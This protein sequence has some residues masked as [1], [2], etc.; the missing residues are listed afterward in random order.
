MAEC[1]VLARVGDLE[2]RLAESPRELQAAQELRFRVFFE[3]GGATPDTVS[4]RAR[5]DICRFDEV[6]DH[7]IVV[8]N[9]A[10]RQPGGAPRVVGAYRL[11]C[12]DA[13]RRHFGFYSAAEFAVDALV[14]RHPKHRFMELGRSCVAEGYRSKRTIETLWRGVWAYAL[15][16]RIDVMFGCASLQGAGAG[17]HASALTLLAREN[18]VEPDWSV[19][20]APHTVRAP[21]PD[22]GGFDPRAA[23]RDLPPLIKGYLRLGARFGR[24]AVIDQSFGTTDVFVVLRV[25]DIEA[26]YLEYFA[27]SESPIAA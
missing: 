16:H 5:R 2:V 15:R 26:R 12:Q 22:G 20:P 3:E 19:A 13:A 27:P 10:P 24:E 1:N 9:A 8:D 25:A 14:E 21:P 11:L 4:A 23:L 18:G 17:A 6:C 7:A